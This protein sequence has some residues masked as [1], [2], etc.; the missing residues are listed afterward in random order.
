M[1]VR[2][3]GHAMRRSAHRFELQT[4]QDGVTLVN[5]HNAKVIEQQP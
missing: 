2:N 1:N 5:E 4:V 3:A